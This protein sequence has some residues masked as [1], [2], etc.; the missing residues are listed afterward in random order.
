MVG[1]QEKLMWRTCWAE[2]RSWPGLVLFPGSCTEQI[3][4][5]S[6]NCARNMKFCLCD[7]SS[8]RLKAQPCKRWI[9]YH[10]A[11][12]RPLK[13]TRQFRIVFLECFYWVTGAL[14]WLPLHRNSEWI[15]FFLPVTVTFLFPLYWGIL[16]FQKWQISS[17]PN[18]KFLVILLVK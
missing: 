9:Y 12:R 15:F 1:L 2:N 11:L 13:C 3:I 17:L 6:L 10:C 16:I 5:L 7:R 4:H 8:P 14:F 18:Y